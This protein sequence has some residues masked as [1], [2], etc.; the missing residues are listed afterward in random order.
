MSALGIESI[1]H[2]V[3]LSHKWI[4]DLDARLGWDDKHRR[5]L[6]TVLQALRDWLS[7][8]AAANFGAQLPELLR[9]IYYERWR[10]VATPVKQRRKADFISRWTERSQQIPFSSL[11]RLSRLCSNLCPTN[12]RLVK[13]STYA[14]LFARGYQ[15][16]LAISIVGRLGGFGVPK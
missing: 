16:A 12:S 11:P 2:T 14:M 7:V 4:N 6:R 15:S 3:E 5:L 1:E 8:N 10:P 9:G 13:S